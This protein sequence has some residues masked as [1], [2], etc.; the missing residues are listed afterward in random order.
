M[1]KSL[2]YLS[3]IDHDWI[4]GDIQV[5]TSKIARCIHYAR[6]TRKI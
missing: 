5:I 3:A 6:L 4:G 2:A 1:L